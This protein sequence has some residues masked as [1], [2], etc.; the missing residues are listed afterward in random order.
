M[1]KLLMSPC[2]TQALSEDYADFI[3]RSLSPIP[4]SL[5]NLNDLCTVPMAVNHL[6]LYAPLDNVLP[7]S[8]N[9]YPYTSIPTLYT[10]EDTSPLESA[11]ILRLQNQP[12][13]ELKGQGTL[14]GI[15]DTGIDYTHE[16]FLDEA[17]KSRI[18]S[19]WDQTNNDGVPP[20]GQFYGTEYNNDIINAALRS[21]TPSA[22]VPETDENGHGTFIAGVACGSE[23]TEAGFIGAAPLAELVVV[24]LKPAKKYLKDYY[25]VRDDAICYQENDI[26]FAISYLLD[27]QQ[28]LSKPLTIIVGLGSNRGDHNGVGNLAF[29]LNRITEDTNTAVCISIGNEGNKRLHFAGKVMN[30]DNPDV[31]ELRIDERQSGLCMEIWGQNPQIFSISVT[32]PTG[33]TISKIPPRLNTSENYTFLFE[34]TVLQV[35]YKLV[36][37]ASGCELILLR[38]ISPSPGI[39][40]INVYGENDTSGVFNSWLPISAFIY[41]DTYFLRSN[42]EITLTSPSASFGPISVATYDSYSNGIYVSSSRGFTRSGN[43][44]PDIASP[45]VNILGPS[46]GNRYTVKSG[47]SIAAALTAGAASQFQTWGITRGNNKEL[48]NND[49]K[50][51][52]IRGATRFTYNQYPNAEWGNGALNIYDAFEVMRGNIN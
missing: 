18:I 39:W 21:E 37:P 42:P 31:I 35:E 49:I 30:N 32:S 38:F 33:E 14:I 11:G 44:K 25:F 43:I 52:I 5:A 22:I 26:L 16:A 47:S 13:L 4:N 40:R 24:K 50:S 12:I 34:Q 19:I 23:N 20:T 46:A 45:G 29:T 7:I 10:I 48:R 28:E 9:K 3:V 2:K 36:E 51:Y 8:I 17:G 27:K 41:D 15:I 6:C 1:V